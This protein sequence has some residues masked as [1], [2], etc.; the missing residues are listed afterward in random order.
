MLR[1]RGV[2]LQEIGTEGTRIEG[3]Q[4]GG[5][6]GVDRRADG[7]G[8]GGEGGDEEIEADEEGV[9]SGRVGVESVGLPEGAESLEVLFCEG[10]ERLV[11]FD[12]QR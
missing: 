1:R 12:G 2:P 11:P 9:E 3:A 7:G 4:E 8:E 6:G 5:K 10:S